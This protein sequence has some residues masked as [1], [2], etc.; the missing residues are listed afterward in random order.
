MS[1]RIEVRLRTATR[2]YE[3]KVLSW[4]ALGRLADERAARAEIARCRRELASS[5]DA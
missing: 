4:Y 1:E 5:D 2:R 3:R